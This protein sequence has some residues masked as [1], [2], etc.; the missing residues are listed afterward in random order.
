METSPRPT[1]HRLPR[2][3]HPLPLTPRHRKIDRLVGGPWRDRCEVER[4]TAAWVPWYNTRRPHLALGGI[5]PQQAENQHT[6]TRKEAASTSLHK[7]RD[8]TNNARATAPV[9]GRDTRYGALHPIRRGAL[10]TDRVHRPPRQ[11]QLRT[12]PPDTP[13]RQHQ[14]QPHNLEIPARLRTRGATPDPSRY[15][16]SVAL[17]PIRRGA[18]PTDRVRTQ[19]Q[20]QTRNLRDD[21]QHAANTPTDSSS[22]CKPPLPKSRPLHRGRILT[23]PMESA[24][25]G[26]VAVAGAVERPESDNGNHPSKSRTQFN[27]VIF[28]D[29]PQTLQFQRPHFNV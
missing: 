6:T 12:V 8:L 1:H 27:A 20:E 25:A 21:R 22:C 13:K 16:R 29:G 9:T 26:Q 11:A 24:P 5:T 3:N 2:P 19:S 7:T 17:H 18:L 28:R 23:V 4:E 15:T 10:P 14:T